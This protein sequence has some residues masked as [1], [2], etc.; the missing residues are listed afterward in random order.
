[1]RSAPGCPVHRR[2]SRLLVPPALRLCRPT[3]SVPTPLR[4]SSSFSRASDNLRPRIHKAADPVGSA[5]WEGNWPAC[6]GW[7]GFSP[8]MRTH[9]SP[10]SRDETGHLDV[11]VVNGEVVD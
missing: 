10:A 11:V 9:C 8:R 2:W 3:A 7:L 1:M 4:Y 6:L 5:A